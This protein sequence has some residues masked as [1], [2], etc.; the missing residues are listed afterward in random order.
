MTDKLQ[1]QQGQG[2]PMCETSGLPPAGPAATRGLWKE[3]RG[4][5][6][7]PRSTHLARLVFAMLLRCLEHPH[8]LQHF[9][10]G[11]VPRSREAA[12]PQ[13]CAHRAEPQPRA[14]HRASCT[15]ARA[16][17]PSPPP[18][19]PPQPSFPTSPP[20][21]CQFPPLLSHLTPTQTPPF[22]PFPVP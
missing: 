17:L 18:P 16:L 6:P 13:H 3:P 2:T 11:T 21:H 5:V 8:C 15:P 9:A 20:R 7:R 10:L 4:S 12:C 22:P 14:S 1:T 19:A